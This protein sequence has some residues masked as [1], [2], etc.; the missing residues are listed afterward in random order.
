M[1]SLEAK[2]ENVPVSL[3]EHDEASPIGIDAS[4]D[5][6]M[7]SSSTFT[8]ANHMSP[9]VEDNMQSSCQAPFIFPTN[10]LSLNLQHD[11]G[12]DFFTCVWPKFGQG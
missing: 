9:V 12:K 2:L 5:S 7:E 3:P 1:N 4:H 11:K 6:G 8:N 10:A